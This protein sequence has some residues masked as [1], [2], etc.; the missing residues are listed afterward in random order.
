MG[1]LS[2]LAGDE[3]REPYLKTFVLN[4]CAICNFYICNIILYVIFTYVNVH[5]CIFVITLIRILI[6]KCV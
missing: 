5:M 1:I 6:Y 2:D 3:N 4:Y